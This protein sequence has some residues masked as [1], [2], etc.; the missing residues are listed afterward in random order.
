MIRLQKLEEPES[1][2]RNRKRWTK[3]LLEAIEAG[4]KKL[5]NQRKKKYNQKDVKEQLRR[6]TKDK[7]AY[8]ESRVTVVAHGDIEHVTPK[9]VKPEHTFEWNNLTF[10][11]QICNQNKS[12]KENIFDPYND[13]MTEIVFLA[14]PYLIGRSIQTQRT[15]IQLDLNRPALIEDRVAH[16]KDFSL[17]LEAIDREQNDELRT[18]LISQLERELDYGEAEYILMKRSLLDGYKKQ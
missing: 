3:E 7:C 4:N 5:V 6:E 16:T 2:K 12:D 9:S 1:L 15:I 11:C 14:P 10:A 18:L 8:C 13:S 17:A